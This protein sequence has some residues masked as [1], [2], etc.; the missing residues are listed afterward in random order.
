MSVYL[1]AI[2]AFQS[3]AWRCYQVEQGDQFALDVW[4]CTDLEFRQLLST[5]RVGFGPVLRPIEE[6]DAAWKEQLDRRMENLTDEARA[7]LDGLGDATR[8]EDFLM[9][10]EGSRIARI[11][12]WQ[13]GQKAHAA[14]RDRAIQGLGEMTGAY[15]AS[16]EDTETQDAYLALPAE[17]KLAIAQRWHAEKEAAEEA[18]R[19]DYLARLEDE[20]SQAAF[21]QLMPDEQLRLAQ[22]AALECAEEDLDGI[23][24]QQDDNDG[25]PQQDGDL[26]EDE[27]DPQ[28][29][30]AFIFD[31]KIHRVE[32]TGGWQRYITDLD[33]NRLTKGLKRAEVEA[34]IGAG[35]PDGDD[36]EG[37]DQ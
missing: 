9:L 18:L 12:R 6:V 30:D 11:E 16:I 19:A 31:G 20:E 24:D 33:G 35:E 3:F 15:Y 8:V 29:D 17:R 32:E 2:V 23:D 26:D 13:Q 22:N 5:G 10:D 4:R 36:P 21:R 7:F 28:Q 27:T 14:D 1:T 25:D 34:L 37:D